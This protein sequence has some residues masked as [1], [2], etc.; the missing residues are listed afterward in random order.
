MVSPPASNKR[1]KSHTSP[2]TKLWTHL[3]DR[4]DKNLCMGRRK[5]E[6]T[7]DEK[8]ERKI[9]KK[10]FKSLNENK[11]NHRRVSNSIATTR[12]VPKDSLEDWVDGIMSDME[13][14]HFCSQDAVDY[15]IDGF[16]SSDE[17]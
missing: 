16:M 9:A 14:K 5:S 13:G 12:G 3:E 10:A 7:T 15:Y 6:L 1:K 4:V 17:E 11:S 8:N 2:T